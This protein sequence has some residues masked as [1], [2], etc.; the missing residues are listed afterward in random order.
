MFILLPTEKQGLISLI[1]LEDKLTVEALEQ[2]MAR[3]EAKTVSIMLPKFRIQQKIQLK[4]L[5]G[6]CKILE[7]F[8]KL[9]KFRN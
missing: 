9:D 1:R 5:L 3:M 8:K 4:V 2:L 7:H 6:F